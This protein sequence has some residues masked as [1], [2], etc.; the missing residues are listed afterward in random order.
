VSARSA[1]VIVIGAG[2]VGASVAFEL[3]SL[4]RRV[5]VA[6]MRHAGAGASQAS[7]GILAPWIEGHHSEGL[8]TLGL[9]SLAMYEEF[10]ERVTHRAGLA[11]EF[12]HPGTLEIA[13]GD[14]DI[15]RLT[16]SATTLA[17][18][19]VASE[20]LDGPRARVIEPTLTSHAVGALRI[21]SHAVVNVPAFTLAAVAAARAAGATFSEGL[22]VTGLE[23]GGDGVVVR[24][25][26]GDLTAP[27]VVLATGSWSSALTPDG[28]LPAPVPP[29]RGQLLHLQTPPG[30]LRHVVWGAHAYLVP[31][32]DGT[33]YVGATSEDVG[34]DERTTV[35]GVASLLAATTALTPG[36]SRATFIEAR[37]GLR[38]GTD[39]TLPFIGPSAALPGL[40]YACGHFRNGALLAPLTAALVAKVV[41]GDLDD[42]A[43]SLVNPSRAGRL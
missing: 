29:V 22:A 43:L 32:A 14:A 8:R 40:V 12:R 17:D 21:P 6:D 37:A 13:V 10:L 28:A 26:Q 30:T 23:A 4:G 34:F 33:I 2:V 11:V 15:E 16:D 35:D 27:H 5:L 39:D 42:P 9:R 3:A 38:P 7:A 36:L 41:R 25:T 20:W 31:W 24:S 19:G 1:E 18:L